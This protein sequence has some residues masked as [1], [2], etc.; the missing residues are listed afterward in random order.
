[1]HI[2]LTKPTL[3]VISIKTVLKEYVIII[4]IIIIIA[5]LL[6]IDHSP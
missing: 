3:F 6:V 1:M 5:S 2:N 4:M